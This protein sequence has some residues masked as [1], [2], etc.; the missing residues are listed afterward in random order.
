MQ[1]VLS[2][3]ITW[4]DAVS[5]L[6]SWFVCWSFLARCSRILMW[7]LILKLGAV[8]VVVRTVGVRL[9]MQLALLCRLVVQM[10]SVSVCSCVHWLLGSRCLS[11]LVVVREVVVVLSFD[12]RPSYVT[13]TFLRTWISLRILLVAAGLG[14]LSECWQRLSV[15]WDLLSLRQ[16]LLSARVSAWC[17]FGVSDV[18]VLSS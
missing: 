12:L 10:C 6:L 11:S 3:V 2:R 13:E 4:S 16:T 5:V 9:S 14:L 15:T 1:P 18:L 8:L 7:L 17:T